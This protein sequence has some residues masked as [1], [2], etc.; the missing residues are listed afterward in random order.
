MIECI[1]FRTQ[2]SGALLGFADF[3]VP[4]M[5]LEIKGCTLFQKNGRRWLNLP[6]KE[7]EKDGEKKYAPIVKFREKEHQEAFATAA[8]K[9]I[10]DFCATQA[11][12]AHEPPS[13]GNSQYSEPDEP[14][15]F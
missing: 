5:G 14:L 12:S 13:Q 8:I 6:S 1:N 7:Y 11:A 2:T 10:D 15:P 9:A 4:K 3:F